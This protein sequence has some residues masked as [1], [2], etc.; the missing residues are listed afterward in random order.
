MFTI[1]QLKKMA[2]ERISRIFENIYGYCVFNPYEDR[3]YM[4]ITIIGHYESDEKYIGTEIAPK[5]QPAIVDGV[6]GLMVYGSDMISKVYSA[7]RN[8]G[9]YEPVRTETKGCKSRFSFSEIMDML[10]ADIQGMRLSDIAKYYET[11][12]AVVIQILT[13][14]TYKWA[15]GITQESF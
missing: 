3:E 15:T 12:S 8:Q 7:I 14:N 10:N 11:S 4:I 13:G 5:V 9:K 6:I 2:T 1:K